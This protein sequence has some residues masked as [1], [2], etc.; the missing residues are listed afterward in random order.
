MNVPLFVDG[1]GVDKGTV[2]K[3][4]ANSVDLFATLLDLAGTAPDSQLDNGPVDSVSLAPVI[5]D[6]TQSVRDFAF[7]DVYGPQ[8]N[9]IVNRQAIRNDR[10]KLILDLQNDTR[11]LYDLIGDPY[12]RSDL[13]QGELDAEAEAG[14][15]DLS[16]QLA[17]LLASL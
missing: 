7:A 12:E 4:L 16:Q 6:H 10:Y 9:Q 13:L 8:Q 2:T 1:P 15:A 14:L 11:E 5:A 3:S 17:E